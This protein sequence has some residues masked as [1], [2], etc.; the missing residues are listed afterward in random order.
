[1]KKLLVVMFSLF[2]FIDSVYAN[3]KIKVVFV[4]CVDGDTAYF[5][6]DGEEKKFRFLAVD[7][8][9]TKHP[10]KGEEEGGATASEFTCN[11]L[12]NAKKIEVEYDPKSDKT[13][14]YDRE[15][16]WVYVDGVMLQETLIK[17][18]YAEVAYIYGDYEYVS[19]LCDVQKTAKSKK[20]GIWYD[21][22]REEGY[23]ATKTNKTTKKVNSTAE[24]KEDNSEL[25][26]IVA[27]IEYLEKG[28]YDKLLSEYGTTTFSFIVIVF[29]II[30]CLALKKK[31]NRK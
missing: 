20:L 3:E 19:S 8:P 28:D 9:E 21:G 15:L 23:C 24:E 31:K 5:E 2:L 18:G 27:F 10:T 14:K 4:K 6:I 7:T 25:I 17:E 1:M 12:K 16:V 29:I 26:D 11:S 30:A 22:K 13:D